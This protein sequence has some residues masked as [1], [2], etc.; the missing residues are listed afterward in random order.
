MTFVLL[1]ILYKVVDSIY[2][3]YPTIVILIAELFYA[4]IS[5]RQ[6]IRRDRIMAYASDAHKHD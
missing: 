4:T 5:I 1:S 3:I 2:L 6:I